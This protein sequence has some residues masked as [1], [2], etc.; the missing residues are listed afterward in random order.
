MSKEGIR[1]RIWS[2][3]ERE[4]VARFPGTKGRIPNFQGAERAARRLSQIEVWREAKRIKAN[5]DMPQ[6]PARE[7]ALSQGKILYMAV[8]RLRSE[9]CFLELD[10]SHLRGQFREAS[11][12]RGAFRLGRPV[13]PEEMDPIDLVV[14]GSVAVTK[15]GARV[16][17]GGGYS[18]L[19]Y[20]IAREIGIIDEETPVVTTVH[21]LQVVSNDIEMKIHDIPV[22]FIVTPEEVIVTLSRF[23]KPKGIYWEI[24]E[25][26]KIKSI[27]ILTR[28]ISTRGRAKGS[29]SP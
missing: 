29:L 7:L 15:E 27:P 9:R 3:L 28:L 1:N 13:N 25:E 23:Q 20:A 11:T 12:I 5:P 16:G 22:D 10:P 8:P 2:L 4:R 21:R 6:R 24:L 18:D 14:A 17:K 19:E 26:E